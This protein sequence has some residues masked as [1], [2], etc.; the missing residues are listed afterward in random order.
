M[1]WP[2]RMLSRQPTLLVDCRILTKP[3][4]PPSAVALPIQPPLLLHILDV[5][6]KKISML[7]KPVAARVY[8]VPPRQIVA[9]W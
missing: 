5:L 9:G 3:T 8:H 6:D 1:L 2:V 7:L 4:S